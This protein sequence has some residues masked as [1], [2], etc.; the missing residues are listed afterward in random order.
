MYIIYINDARSSKYQDN[1]IYLLIKYT[2]SVLW[3]VAKRLSYIEDVR[4]LK[5]KSITSPHPHPTQEERKVNLCEFSFNSDFVTLPHDTD[6][7]EYLR[8]IARLL[9]KVPENTKV[10]NLIP[11]LKSV[12]YSNSTPSEDG[13]IDVSMNSIRHVTS[14]LVK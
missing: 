4:C 5:V 7:E 2:K 14:M 1:E 6:T 9:P 8:N 10:E 11:K 12:Y 3:R 13:T